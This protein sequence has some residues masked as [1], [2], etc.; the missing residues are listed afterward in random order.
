MANSGNITPEEYDKIKE[1][2]SEI[3]RGN[4][5][6]F[7]LVKN[8]TRELEQQEGT[9]YDMFISNE[10]MRQIIKDLLSKHEEYEKLQKTLLEH[11]KKIS[12]QY[13]IDEKELLNKEKLAEKIN[14]EEKEKE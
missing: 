1:I 8:I 3:N 10:N 11:V 4:E 7:N 6:Y 13:G 14:E 5:N 12:E 9:Y 2:L